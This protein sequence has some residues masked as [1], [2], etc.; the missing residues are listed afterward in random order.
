VTSEK[1]QQT[2]LT[3]MGLIF[4]GAGSMIV[5][6]ALDI[7]PVN[8]ES[9]EAPR[10][11]VGAAGAMFFFLGLLVFA[12][13][14]AGPGGEQVI[15]FQWVQ[16]MLT[17]GALIS[18]SSVFIWAGLGA[19][20]RQFQSSG[21]IGPI[22]ISGQGGDLLGRCMFGGF[23]LLVAVG[24]LFYA[25]NRPLQLLGIDSEDREGEQHD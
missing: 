12:Q 15:L 20:E 24:T 14:I 21:S 17:L 11:V 9:L 1:S 2:I 19:G 18:F 6:L 3:L 5:F 8:P 25:L 10:W 23:G 16:Y 7:I 4:V 22:G 13:G